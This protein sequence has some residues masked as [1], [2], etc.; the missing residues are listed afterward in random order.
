MISVFVYGTLMVGESNHAVAAPYVVSVQPGAVHGELYNV[1]AYPAL[2]LISAEGGKLQ[3]VI[4][5]WLE[6][7][8]EGLAAMDELEDYYGPGE[9]NEYERVFVRDVNG[10]REGWV[11]V[12]E[13]ISGLKKI[14]SGS[15]RAIR[16]RLSADRNGEA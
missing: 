2:L 15:W 13:D 12:W 16:T 14:R 10:L 1:G 7:T 5:E 8:E 4:G 11:Y 3:Q 9:A 6:V